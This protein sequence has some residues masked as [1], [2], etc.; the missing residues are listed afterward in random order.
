MSEINARIYKFLSGYDNGG[1]NWADAADENHG[2]DDGT[3]IYKE[4]QEFMEKNFSWNGEG[5][6]ERSDIIM[7]FWKKI[8]TNTSGSKISGTSIRNDGALD[9]KELGNIEEELKIYVAFDNLVKNHVKIPAVLT[10][11]GQAWK[12]EV[13]DKLSENLENFIKEGN[14]V[15]DLETA[16]LGWYAEIKNPTFAQ[17]YAT[18]YTKTLSS[19]LKNYP[20]YKVADDETLQNLISTY[21]SGQSADVAESTIVNDIKDIMD[22]YL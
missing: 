7:D 8:D 19:L 17:Y 13:V 21:I 2:N 6:I 3:V 11:T 10:S 1:K 18:E 14:N 4:F 9:K 5:S 20:E 16:F 15:D 12:K 22:A